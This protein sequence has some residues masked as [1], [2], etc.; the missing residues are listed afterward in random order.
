MKRLA[1]LV[2]VVVVFTGFAACDDGDGGGGG[3]G[4]VIA[5]T[6]SVSPPSYSGACPVTFKFTGVITTNGACRVTY[7]WVH[8][9]YVQDEKTI[10]F[11][12]AG[13]RTVEFYWSVGSWLPSNERWL[14][15]IVSAPNQ[16]IASPMAQFTLN[17]LSLPN[18]NIND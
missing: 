1:L 5:V 7:R 10:E 15:L 4:Q 8:V 6:S 11:N 18:I 16:F 14:D 13:S 9:P 17:C 3:N 12:A 2:L